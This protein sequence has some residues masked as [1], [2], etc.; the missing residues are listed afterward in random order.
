[1]PS[2]RQISQ[3]SCI[4]FSYISRNPLLPQ[5]PQDLL[6]GK[7]HSLQNVVCYRKDK[8]AGMQFLPSPCEI[9]LLLAEV[10]NASGRIGLFYC[11]DMKEQLP[12]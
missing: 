7:I 3:E 2:L 12:A 4:K 5:R 10:K 6:V 11:K 9:E 1:M 8:A